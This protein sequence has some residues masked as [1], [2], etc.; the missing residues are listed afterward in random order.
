[1]KVGNGPAAIGWTRPNNVIAYQC[2]GTLITLNYVMTAAH[3][4]S[5]STN[6]APDTVRLGDIDLVG[7][8]NDRNAQQIKIRNIARHPDFM[9]TMAYNDIALLQLAQSAQPTQFVCTACLWPT[10]NTFSQLTLLGFGSTVPI[11]PI[12]PILLKGT[13]PTVDSTTCANALLPARKLPQ[14]ILNTQICA[15]GSTIDGCPG[16]SGGPFLTQSADNDK[17]IPFVVG[18]ASVGTSCGSRSIGVYTRIASFVGWIQSVTGADFNQLRCARNPTC[19]AFFPDFQSPAR[20]QST[21]P[22][23]RAALVNNFQYTGCGA[24]LIDYRHLLTAAQCVWGPKKPNRVY[25][26]GHVLNIEKIFVHPRF[27]KRTL[28]HDLALIQVD[29]FLNLNP[30]DGRRIRPACL[31]TNSSLDSEDVF[32]AAVDPSDESYQTMIIYS[33]LTDGGSSC[34]ANQICSHNEVH[35]VPGTCRYEVGGHT[36]NYAFVPT[37]DFVPYIYGVNSVGSDCG[38]D[39][40]NFLATKVANDFD[41]IESVVLGKLSS[42]RPGVRN[43]GLQMLK[44]CLPEA[45]CVTRVNRPR[46]MIS[47]CWF[48]QSSSVTEVRTKSPSRDTNVLRIV[49]RKCPGGNR[50]QKV[51]RLPKQSCYG[52]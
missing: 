19:R 46:L 37:Q 27:S 33:N 5:D 12:S 48:N 29:K 45:G 1:M 42:S 26:H 23:C 21:S 49:N 51:S 44:N 35:I 4:T 18:I 41:W 16:D 7:M 34:K 2:G 11:G 3:C 31:W 24:T 50:R 14:G 20:V 9:I 47:K 13:I 17:L 39:T 6:A 15:G 30:Y 10:A 43:E 8:A 28:D 52:R 22:V 40:G 38:G 36:S 25:L 32:V